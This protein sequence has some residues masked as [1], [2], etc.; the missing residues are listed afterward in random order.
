MAKVK[1]LKAH[2]NGY[3]KKFIKAKGDEYEHPD[4]DALID[5]KLIELVDAPKADEDDGKEGVKKLPPPDK[6][7]K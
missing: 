2:N 3:G 4:P 7:T 6:P 1:T 5:A